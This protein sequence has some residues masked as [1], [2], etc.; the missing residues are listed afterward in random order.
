MTTR[1]PDGEPTAAGPDRRHLAARLVAGDHP[2]IG[3]R[4]PAQVLAVDRADVAA[5]DRRGLHPHQHLA[6]SRLGDIDLNMLDGAVAGKDDSAHR[7][8]DVP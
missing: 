2:L 1:S 7:Y 4:S 6:M 5:A 3:L 8:H